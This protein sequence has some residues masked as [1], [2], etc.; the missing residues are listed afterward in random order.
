MPFIRGMVPPLFDYC[1]PKKVG[2][3]SVALGWLQ[4]NF[5]TVEVQ[6]TSALRSQCRNPLSAHQLHAQ[7]QTADANG[8]RVS[9]KALGECSASLGLF[10]IKDGS[11]PEPGD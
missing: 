8:L 2:C 3:T 4:T 7:P 9:D 5:T 1:G 11:Q 6:I 10:W